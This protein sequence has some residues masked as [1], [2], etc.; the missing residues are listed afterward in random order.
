[1]IHYEFEELELSIK[2]SPAEIYVYGIA[3]IRC[4]AGEAEFWDVGAITLGRQRLHPI[5]H[6]QSRFESDLWHAIVKA[7]TDKHDFLIQ[8]ALIE[9]GA[10]SLEWAAEHR[11]SKAQM[12]ISR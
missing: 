11:L 3:E 1:M 10:V 12:G 6:G 9:A 8:T 5:G 2:G 7:L 4:D